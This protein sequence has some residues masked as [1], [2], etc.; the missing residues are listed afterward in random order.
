[1]KDYAAI[2]ALVSLQIYRHMR[3]GCDIPPP[4]DEQD[5]IPTR[6]LLDVWHFMD[7][8]K[9]PRKHAF[10]SLFSRQFRDIILHF[11][12]GDKQLVSEYLVTKGTFKL[13][14]RDYV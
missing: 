10:L 2:D 8:L 9:L 13:N 4:R 7:R 14:S 1:M 3:D 5:G 12:P 6:C 11:N